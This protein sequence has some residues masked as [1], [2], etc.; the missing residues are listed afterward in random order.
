MVGL[1]GFRLI[2]EILDFSGIF[3]NFFETQH[4][5]TIPQH[6]EIEGKI[7]EKEKNR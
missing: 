6:S 2:F 1:F 4:S 7:V 3:G 5:W